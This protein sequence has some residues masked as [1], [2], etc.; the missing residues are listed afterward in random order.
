MPMSEEERRRCILLGGCT[1]GMTREV[2]LAE[3]I[4]DIVSAHPEAIKEGDLAGALHA[5]AAGLIDRGFVLVL[6]MD[7][8][9]DAAPPDES[10]AE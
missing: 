2:A 1:E 7:P 4:Q 9:K 3:E 6:G 5:I 10:A 8:A